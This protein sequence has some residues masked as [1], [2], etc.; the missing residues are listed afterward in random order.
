MTEQRAR[1]HIAEG[2]KALNPGIWTKITGGS[3]NKFDDAAAAFTK[4]GNVYKMLKKWDEGGN[5]FERAAQTYIQANSSHEAATAYQNASNCYK[6]T[7]MPD[8]VRCLEA[9]CDIYAAD[10]KFSLAAKHHK[11]MAEMFE[12]EMDLDKSSTHYDRAADFFDNENQPS[13]A[14]TC[15]LKV[16]RFAAEKGDF[17]KAIEIWEKAAKDSLDAGNRTASYVCKEY[18][19]NAGLCYIARDDVVGLRQAIGRYKDLQVSFDRDRECKL[20]EE[21]AEA[22]ENYDSEKLTNVVSE[23]NSLTRLEPWKINLLAKVKGGLKEDNETEEGGTDM[24]T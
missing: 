7:S 22:C 24:L 6:N 15:R 1:E 3:H 23:Y 5:I 13:S 19:L 11:T 2:E 10:G 17:A 8:A 14:R 20:L 18:F 9:A 21:L 4:A 16:A 12:K